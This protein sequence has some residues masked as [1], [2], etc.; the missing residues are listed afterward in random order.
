MISNF[1]ISFTK[2]SG[3]GNDFI[4]MD[5]RQPLIAVSEQPDFARKICRRMFSIGADGL[6]LIE[7]SGTADFSWRFYNADGSVAEMCG[8]GA[9]CAAR[10]AFVNKIAG[11][12][13]TFATLAGIIEAEVLDGSE[14]VRLRMTPPSDFRQ[15]LKLELGGIEREVYFINTGVPH[16]VIFVE[17]GGIPVKEWGREVRFHPLFQP[18]GSNANFVRNL[19]SGELQVRTY[20]RGVEDETKA[21]GTGAVAS[22]LIAGVLG[23]ADSPVR[24]ITSGGEPLTVL[25]DLKQGPKIDNVFLQGPARIIYEGQLTAESLL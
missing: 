15:G 1:P 4:V 13:M 16:A 3:T 9:R 14:I 17:N 23:R 10:Y 25:F 7:K 8:N 5:H 18:A 11:P 2:M 24:C 6:I 19:A 20:E 22:A 21:C 12:K